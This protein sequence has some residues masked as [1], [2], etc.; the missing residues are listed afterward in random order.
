M[1]RQLTSQKLNFNLQTIA[2]RRNFI[3][4]TQPLPAKANTI[5]QVSTKTGI[6][7]S[8]AASPELFTSHQPLTSLAS[9]TRQC[10]K[11]ATSSSGIKC[12]KIW[13]NKHIFSY[14]IGASCFRLPF[15]CF[16]FIPTIFFL[17]VFF[18][19]LIYHRLFLVKIRIFNVR[20]DTLDKR[21]VNA[22]VK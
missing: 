1:R 4:A 19:K 3:N 11:T 20:S 5:L 10:L 17:S 9:H 14:I 6:I 8:T 15:F 21:H 18:T 16:S 13:C 22:P 2:L 12:N 7:P